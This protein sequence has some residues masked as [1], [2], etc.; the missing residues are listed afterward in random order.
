MR[1]K[2]WQ[3]YCR[4]HTNSE[5]TSPHVWNG[6][7]FVRCRKIQQNAQNVNKNQSSQS[8]MRNVYRHPMN[9]KEM[10]A[11]NFQ[12]RF[13]EDGKE[14][15][16]SKMAGLTREDLIDLSAKDLAIKLREVGLPISLTEAL[17]GK[18][19]IYCIFV[20]CWCYCAPWPS[21]FRW[22]VF[23][24]SE[25]DKRSNIAT[26]GCRRY[27]IRTERP[28]CWRQDTS[29]KFSSWNGEIIT[30]NFLS[31]LLKIAA[32]ARKLKARQFSR[33]FLLI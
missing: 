14:E 1:K 13:R 20:A 15:W 4:K 8:R 16:R 30:L 11:K 22:F 29:A 10:P 17:H 25:G 23:N 28:K 32:K 6:L 5:D 9:R 19:C 27:K 18:C 3:R 21:N 24:N 26:D 2:Y 31:N 7:K 33:A 12:P